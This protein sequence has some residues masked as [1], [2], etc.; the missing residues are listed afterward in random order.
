MT[1]RIIVALCFVAALVLA[2][3]ITVSADVIPEPS[4]SFYTRNSSNC[5][6]LQRS[7]YAN[8]A[9]GCVSLR[10]EPGSASEV[11]VF[12]N[13]SELFIMFTYNKR[14]V[15]WGVTEVFETRQS[16]WIPMDDLLLVYD[17]ISFEEDYHDELYVFS[18]TYEVL[19]AITDLIFWTWPGSGEIDR[20][21]EARWRNSPEHEIAFLE[22]EKPAYKDA[23][24]REW[25]FIPYLF[26]R[27]NAWICLDDP[28]NMDIPAFHP[29]P[30]PVFR[31]SGDVQ[32][33]LSGGLSGEAHPV[34]PQWQPG[35][36]HLE[37]PGGLALP[38]MA[39]ILVVALAVA[40]A[41]LIW[42][43]WKKTNSADSRGE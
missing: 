39:I 32:R 7:F 21:L 22:G 19:A 11:A 36:E 28:L 29:A 2:L 37:Q 31:Q 23:E 35:K 34:Q 14:G 17:Y 1:K 12:E 38:L 15:I 4:N 20:I 13:G 25:V 40:T 9:D 33:D 3:P 16:G 42:L 26:G 41:V 8:G 27:T 30:E 18:G 10:A 24:G 5:V 6:P 43:F